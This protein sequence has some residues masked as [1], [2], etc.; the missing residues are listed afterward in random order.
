MIRDLRKGTEDSS[1]WKKR[2]SQNFFCYETFQ[3]IVWHSPDQCSLSRVEIMLK[4]M[5]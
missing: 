1:S 2:K 4:K 3:L 5:S